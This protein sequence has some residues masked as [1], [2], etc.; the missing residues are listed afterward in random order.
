LRR[1]FVYD[2]ATAH[3]C[4]S[5]DRRPNFPTL[6]RKEVTAAPTVYRSAFDILVLG[7][8]RIYFYRKIAVMIPTR[9]TNLRCEETIYGTGFKPPQN[10]P[11]RGDGCSSR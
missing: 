8:I 1:P 4:P 9:A 2:E 10:L 3:F 5:I 6:N 7:R 11:N